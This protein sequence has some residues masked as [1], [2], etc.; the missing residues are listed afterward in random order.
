[1]KDF[2]GFEVARPRYPGDAS[3]RCLGEVREDKVAERLRTKASTSESMLVE[4]EN[5]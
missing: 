1:M 5:K 2:E 3:T 4:G